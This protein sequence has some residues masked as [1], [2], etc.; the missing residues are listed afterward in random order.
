MSIIQENASKKKVEEVKT[1]LAAVQ[2]KE[3]QITHTP[4]RHPNYNCHFDQRRDQN[5]H[6]QKNYVDRR[7]DQHAKQ[8]LKRLIPQ[9][10]LRASIK[11]DL[12]WNT[13]DTM[14]QFSLGF[15]NSYRLI[16]S[17]VTITKRK[18]Y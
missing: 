16:S 18:R 17:S 9:N 5:K 4:Y 8:Q 13:A 2:K 12:G 10:N 15:Y 14:R 3:K 6:S 7:K 1:I 11:V